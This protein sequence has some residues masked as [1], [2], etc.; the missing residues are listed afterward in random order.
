MTNTQPHEDPTYAKRHADRNAAKVKMVLNCTNPAETVLDIG[1]NAGYVTQALLES[2][3]AEYARG[4]EMSRTTVSPDLLSRDDFDLFEGNILDFHFDR[5]YDLIIY[6]AVH[7]HVLGSY[8]RQVAWK[9]WNE[10]IDHCG[11]A[12]IFETGIPSEVGNFYWKPPIREEFRS[13]AL[14]LSALRRSV[15]PRLKDLSVIGRLPIHLVKRPIYRFELH[16]IGGATD[17][18]WRADELYADYRVPDDQWKT[19]GRYRRTAGSHG[20]ELMADSSVRDSANVDIVSATEFYKLR[21][22]QSGRLFFAKKHLCDPYKEM[23]EFHLLTS[24]SHPRIIDLCGVSEKYGLIFPYLPWTA[25]EEVRMSSIRNRRQFLHEVKSV[26][27]YAQYREITTGL[28]DLDDPARN[29]TRFLHQM[30]DLHMNNFLLSVK[31]NE[32]RDW[33]LIDLEY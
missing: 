31:G 16:P 15:G 17:L 27:D 24:V 4:V 23:R 28:L 1:C 21:N 30:V 13:H 18:K 32:I 25:M 26:F 9:L 12:L 14:H 3:Q 20:Q 8:G 19:I 10:I 22:K 6:N 33:R 5:T 2:G 29:R 11:R 7:H